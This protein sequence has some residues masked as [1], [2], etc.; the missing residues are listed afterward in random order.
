MWPVQEPVPITLQHHL[1]V[2]SLFSQL[3]VLESFS[4]PLR[5]ALVPT[6]PEQYLLAGCEEG[7]F[8]WN[9]KLEK[10]QKNR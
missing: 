3:L 1:T 9:I 2:R 4:V 5:I 6:C 7:C 10:E 8:T